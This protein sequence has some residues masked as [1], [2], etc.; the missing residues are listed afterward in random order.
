MKRAAAA[1]LLAVTLVTPTVAE[2]AALAHDRTADRWERR[3]NHHHG[4]WIYRRSARVQMH[5]RWHRWNDN[6]DGGTPHRHETT[7]KLRVESTAYCLRGRMS[8]GQY[9]YDGAAAMN[10][11]PLGTKFRVLSGPLRGRTLAVKDRIGSGSQ[12]DV[13]M[14]GRCRAA[15]NYGRRVI[16]IRRV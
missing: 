14:P 1:A 5:R 3:H 2:H 10:G 4:R 16:N 7:G 8:N 13:A 9:T 6:H 12:F 15:T 11:V